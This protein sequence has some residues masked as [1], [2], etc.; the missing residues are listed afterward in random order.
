MSLPERQP[1]N[2]VV[3]SAADMADISTAGSTY[4]AAPCTGKLVR[5]YL[6]AQSAITGADC[7]WTMEINGVAVTGTGTLPVASA[8][9]GQVSEV[10]F[11]APVGV[12][13]G[14]TIE[15]ISGGESST[16]TIGKFSAV[17]RT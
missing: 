5:A 6:C 14:D 11:S 12:N 2:E 1:S 13:K 3:V 8:A 15:W 17:L 7:T 4:A 16:T 9:I 10:T